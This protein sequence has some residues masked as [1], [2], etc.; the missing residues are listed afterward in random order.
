[1]QTEEQMQNF[2]IFISFSKTTNNLNGTFSR[3]SGVFPVLA[4][5][6]KSSL[7]TIPITKSKINRIIK[8]AFFINVFATLFK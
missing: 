1:L 3:V 2:Q 7:M 8:R 4:E 6:D 5:L